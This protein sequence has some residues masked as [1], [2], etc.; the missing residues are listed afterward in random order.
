MRKSR[1]LTGVDCGMRRRGG[2]ASSGRAARTQL[3]LDEQRQV[4]G[5]N[6]WVRAALHLVLA[7][8]L[9]VHLAQHAQWAH[10]VTRVE[11]VVDHALEVIPAASNVCLDNHTIFATWQQLHVKPM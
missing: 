5:R 8:P 9:H 7:E 6:V 3:D 1:E 11:D 4:V 2:R 10:D